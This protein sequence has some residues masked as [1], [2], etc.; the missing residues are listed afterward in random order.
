MIVM[1]FG[2]SSLKD[3]ERVRTAAEI[4]KG[5]LDRS[6]LVVVSAHAKVTDMLIAA[7]RSAVQGDPY[8][9]FA[10]IEERHHGILDELEIDHEILSGNLK[11]LEE[12]LRGISLVKELTSRTLDFAMSFGERMSSKVFAAHLRQIGIE[13]EAINSY[14]IGFTTDSNFGTARPTPDAPELI[15]EAVA[16]HKDSLVVTTG[17]VGKNKT[18]EIT[19]VGRNGSDFSAAFFGA[20]LDAEEIQIWTDVDGVLTAD[21]SLVK[22]AKSIPVLT[23]SEASE[24][25]YYGGQ[26]LHPSTMIPAV[27]K[28]IPIRVLNTYKPEH[29]G[30]VI[31]ADAEDTG[32]GEVRSV[33]YKEDIYLVHVVSTRMHGQAGFMAQLFE[34]F[35]RHDIVIDMIATSE[36]TVSLTTDKPDGL[37]AAAQDLASISR[38]R[39]EPGK[40]IICVVGRGMRHV[41]GL[42]ARVFKAVAGAGVNIQMI[43]QGASE[44]NIAFI[45]NNEDI[46]PAV[47]SLHKEFFE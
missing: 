2:G 9:G 47:R 25:A 19:T 29:P 41:V 45:V 36:V 46:G 17:F 31:I 32:P 1:K 40:A 42:A 15:R 11:A 21:P 26:V 39:I 4:V 3:G 37:E 44:I 20:A 12:L 5:R 8:S 18:G 35:R 6:P 22:A 16:N 23:F 27:E 28:K 30:S 13:A 14:D 34:A 33:V 43:S 10:A 38:V 24:V 7:A